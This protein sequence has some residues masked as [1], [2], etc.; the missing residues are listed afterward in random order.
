MATDGKD[1]EAPPSVEDTYKHLEG[2]RFAGLNQ[3]TAGPRHN[4]PLP[5][6]PAEFQLYS[7]A[8]PNGQKASIGCEEF[9]IEYNAHFINIQNADQFS[10]GFVAINPNSRIPC[11]KH[12]DVRIFESG[13][14]LLYLAEKCKKFLPEDKKAEAYSWL[15]WQMSGQGPMFGQFGHYFRY[16]PRTKTEAI[17]YGVAR[18]GM[19]VRRLLSVMENHLKD[20]RTW[21]LGDEYSIIDMA[22]YP[23]VITLDKGYEAQKF[24]GRNERYPNVMKWCARMAERPAVQRGMLVCGGPGS[25]EK[26][27]K[28]IAKQA[29]SKL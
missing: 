8:T 4:R 28:L 12:G 20:G 2:N 14:I 6:G 23:W 27:K 10:E 13:A 1:W 19:E 11:M 25:Q 26:L 24:I 18:Y 9:G 16:A 17:N 5:V 21:F 29:E 15:M 3:D 7:L 22:M